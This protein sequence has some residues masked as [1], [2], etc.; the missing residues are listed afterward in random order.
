MSLKTNHRR[1][2]E[3]GHPVVGDTHLILCSRHR[4]LYYTHV[5][6]AG[7]RN[8]I[9][10]C[11]HFNT[12]PRSWC[13]HASVEDS[14]YCERHAN[15]QIP[16]DFEDNVLRRIDRFGELDA[17]WA[18]QL[19]I[20]MNDAMH[21]FF[22]DDPR[23]NEALF[24]NFFVGM[25][26]GVVLMRP[27]LLPPPR[28]GI[29]AEVPDRLDFADPPPVERRRLALLAHDNQN[30]HTQ[31][32]SA[33]TNENTRRIL[34][35]PVDNTQRS[36]DVL[37]TQWNLIH[38]YTREEKIRVALDVDRFFHLRHCRTQPPQEPDDL[39]RKMIRGLV[40][41]I[42]RVPDP[43]IQS[44]L[45]RRMFEEC[46]DAVDMC[47]EGHLARLANVLVGFDD[48]YRSPV[49]QGELI[50]NRISA[51]Y[52]MELPENE[53]ARLATAFFD[54]IALPLGEREPWLT[55]LVE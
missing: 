29:N 1:C 21:Q 30:I 31:E 19:N 48:N 52:A 20:N 4:T 11:F 41:Y 40:A 14:I 13:H 25:D 5:E 47:I 2:T 54:E 34:A 53:K 15:R 55:A 39:Y 16:D 23:R 33:Q 22:R 50:Q 6:Q 42:G 8:Q 35:I 28:A 49:S 32:V 12:G 3:N 18:W 10:R 36:R 24:G 46:R 51:I 26:P 44:N 45:W 27:R 37:F 9:G 43:E 7:I 38:G 17:R